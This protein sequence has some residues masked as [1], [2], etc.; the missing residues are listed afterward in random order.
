M[1]I[2]GVPTFTPLPLE[3]ERH[4]PSSALPN[5]ARQVCATTSDVPVVPRNAVAKGAATA[6][7][8]KAPAAR[9]C[10]AL[11]FVDVTRC[12]PYRSP[13]VYSAPTISRYAVSCSHVIAAGLFQQATAV[14]L[15]RH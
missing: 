5:H 12:L 7:T 8:A 13:T 10:R 2:S 14:G 1:P 6:A 4:L 9:S 3:Y 11:F 15:H